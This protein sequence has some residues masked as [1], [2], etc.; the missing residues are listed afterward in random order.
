MTVRR[1]VN[2]V[3][4]TSQE[5]IATSRLTV[6]ELDMGEDEA[7]TWMT[8]HKTDLEDAVTT[9]ENPIKVV[10]A[11]HNTKLRLLAQ[12]RQ[13]EKQAGLPKKATSKS[14]KTATTTQA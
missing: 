5:T 1:Q 10:Y 13:A 8:K 2:S 7:K 6:L 3:Y 14:R 9:I 12:Q 11:L 4:E